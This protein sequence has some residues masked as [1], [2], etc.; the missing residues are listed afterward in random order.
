MKIA[1]GTDDAACFSVR[2]LGDITDPSV[3]RQVMQVQQSSFLAFCDKVVKK[4]SASDF[5][6]SM[7]DLQASG[8]VPVCKDFGD[9]DVIATGVGPS[10]WAHSNLLDLHAMLLFGSVL[11]LSATKQPITRALRIR[12]QAPLGLKD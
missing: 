12:C 7:D 1:V 8:L 10:G 4:C 11:Q 6:G 2:L 3:E 9:I 5:R